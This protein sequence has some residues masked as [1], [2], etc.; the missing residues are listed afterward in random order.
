MPSDEKVVR[1]FMAGA[2]VPFKAKPS[3]PTLAIGGRKYVLSTDGGPLGDREDDEALEAE[4]ENLVLPSPGGDKWRYLWAYDTEKQILAMWRAASG[5]NKMLGGARGEQAIIVQLDR[6]GQLNRVNTAEFRRIE[7]FMN[8]READLERAL[9]E[10][11]EAQKG[12]REK[13]IDLEVRALFKRLRPNLEREIAAVRSGAVPIGFKP[14]S[15]QNVE[16]QAVTYVVGQF[17]RRHLDPGKLVE[18]LA[19]KIPG[20]DPDLAGHYQDVQW[21]VDEIR[22]ASYDEFVN[23][24]D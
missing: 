12:D 17:F 10:S 4:Y 23:Q 14:H 5:S 15:P 18:E 20:L 1:R 11:I 19:G 24:S 6:K 3:G 13:G 7:S 16:R 22:D 2:V 9:R 8:D 21:A